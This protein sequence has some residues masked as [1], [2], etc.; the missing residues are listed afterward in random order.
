MS[1]RPSRPVARAL[2]KPVV[3]DTVA[4]TLSTTAVAFAGI[5]AFVGLVVAAM[6]VAV[7]LQ[8]LGRVTFLRT[9]GRVGQ[10]VLLAGIERLLTPWARAG[11]A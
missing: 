9:S 3:A 4:V 11:R 10:D 2:T 6:L 1:A 5:I 8:S 7:A